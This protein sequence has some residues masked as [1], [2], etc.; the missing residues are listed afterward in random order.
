MSFLDVVSLLP[1]LILLSGILLL[2]LLIS[3]VRGHQLTMLVS[4]FIIIATLISIPYSLESRVG[5]VLGFMRLDGYTAF[6]NILFLVSAL[7]TVLLGKHYFNRR[8]GDQDEFYLLLLIST[9]GAMVLGAAEHFA[10]FLL[11][12]EIMSISL[13]VIIAYP[14]EGN[15][16]LE[17]AL[18]YLVL[19][20]VATTVMLFGMALLYNSTG[21][22]VIAELGS[23]NRGGMGIEPPYQDIFLI[24]GHGL[25]IT[26]LAFKL[27]LVPMHMWTPDVVQGAPAPVAGYL[28]TVSKASVFAFLM[29]YVLE[30]GAISIAEVLQMLAFFAVLSMVI[31]NF[32]ALQ[33]TNLKRLLGYSS[34]AHAGYLVITLIAAV[35]LVGVNEAVE[36][37][38][39]Y[40]AGYALMTLTSFGVISALSSG[41]EEKDA[42]D[43]TAYKGLFWRQPLLATVFTISLLSLAGIPLT[44][45]FVAKFYLFTAGIE[46]GLW[47]L[48]WTLVA[49]S[50]V[51]IYYYL[52]VILAMTETATANLGKL[53]IP[54]SSN[55]LILVLLGILLLAFG[56]YPMPL[57][58]V[59]RSALGTF[60]GF[61][62]F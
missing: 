57:I 14:E 58:E 29:R 62:V 1:Y 40:L 18:K 20:G 7:V 36:A 54:S 15:P 25:L 45:G 16:P 27:S 6:F 9:L 10:A 59:M 17:A 37:A 55:I 28:A 46:G 19:S 33:Q 39:F 21:T 31:G 51:A 47:V 44:I 35:T 60:S 26:G 48:V 42:Q 23:N 56:I 30:S 8:S 43:L 38:M 52:R 32:L 50:A 5:S 4:V 61:P 49:G 22:L 53:Y 34:I 24:V 12:L 11:G 13:Y 2:V 41:G 3:F